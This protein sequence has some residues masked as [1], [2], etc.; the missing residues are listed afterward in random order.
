MSEFTNVDRCDHVLSLLCP[1][2]P[3]GLLALATVTMLIGSAC[4]TRGPVPEPPTPTV[5]LSATAV[6][7]VPTATLVP[8]P[9]ATEQPKPTSTPIVVARPTTA[10]ATTLVPTTAPTRPAKSVPTTVATVAR[11][12]R[13]ATP[14]FS[15]VSQMTPSD[16]VAYLR[17][18]L[19]G[20]PGSSPD[21][22]VNFSPSDILETMDTNVLDTV[23][24]Q[25]GEVALQRVYD[26]IAQDILATMREEYGDHWVVVALDA[27]HGGKKG[28]N[29]DPGS[30]G[31]EAEH[32]RA[33]V[34]AMKRLDKQPEYRRIILRPIYND[35]IADDFGL[36]PPRNTSTV[37]ETLMRQAR[38]SML[39]LQAA[40]WNRA[41]SDAADRVMVHE[42][43]IHF[44]VGAG[45]A[46]VLHQG[47]TVRPEFVS[48]SVDFARRYLQRVTADLNATGI[49]PSPLGLWGG[50]GLHDDVMMYRPAAFSAPVSGVTLRYGALQGHGFLPRFISIVLAHQ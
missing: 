12:V 4:A 25:K 22:V 17:G 34:A 9:T 46:M 2:T 48:R 50:T 39:A 31:T 23:K 33:V 49:L 6:P 41:H 27:G 13:N 38:A 5:S 20:Y 42:I 7:I 8:A 47:N 37:N 11:D 10:T 32:T 45:G 18:D 43:S 40:A 35:Q 16:V 24:R 36:P 26:V 3:R 44:N 30:E 28:F 29:W 1:P 21:S 14:N 15:D 19:P